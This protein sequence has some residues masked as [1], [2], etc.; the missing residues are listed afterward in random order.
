MNIVYLTD[1]SQ[2]KINLG[3]KRSIMFKHAAPKKLAF[4]SELVMLIVFALKEITKERITQAH[5]DKVKSLLQNEPKERIIA[6]TGLMPSWI[7]S[8]LMKLYE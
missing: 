8:I 3:D 4:R 2:R 7:K 1:G 5:L 6:D